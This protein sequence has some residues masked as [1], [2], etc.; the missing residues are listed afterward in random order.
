VSSPEVLDRLNDV[1]AAVERLANAIAEETQE[2]I[3]IGFSNAP[4][5]AAP[6]PADER[7]LRL[8]AKI[9]GRNDA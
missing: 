6:Q 8:R 5:P 3:D 1:I 7:Y 9:A 4:T 2:P